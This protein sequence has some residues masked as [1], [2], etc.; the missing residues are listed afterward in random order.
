LDRKIRASRIRAISLEVP[1]IMMQKQS[2][3]KATSQSPS[4]KSS[5]K[6][7]KHMAQ[8]NGKLSFMNVDLSYLGD[9]LEVV[10]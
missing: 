7:G 8:E 10:Q 6:I 3:R 5:R 9:E 2:R 4:L 1:S